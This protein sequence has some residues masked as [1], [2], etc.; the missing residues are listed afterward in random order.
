MSKDFSEYLKG[1]KKE[2]T[3]SNIDLK[4]LE[5]VFDQKK[6]EVKWWQIVI[7]NS[8]TTTALGILTQPLQVIHTT[9]QLSIKRMDFQ[10]N[11]LRDIM[12]AKITLGQQKKL[13]QILKL[14]IVKYQGPSYQ[15]YNAVFKGLGEQGVLGFYKGLGTGILY[16]I[17]N[18]QLRYFLIQK[19]FN[20][21][22]LIQNLYASLIGMAVDVLTNPFMLIQSKMI[23]QNRLPNF[24]TYRSIYD[25]L[26]KERNLYKGALG[27]IY[28]HIF[29]SLSQM[30]SIY[31]ND[32]RLCLSYLLMI[33][34]V[35]S[36]PF[37]T[38][39]RRLH[40]QGSQPFMLQT[41]YKGFWDGAKQI[42]QQEGILT[43][44][45]G[46]AAF[47]IAN[48]FMAFVLYSTQLLGESQE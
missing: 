29:I 44:Y 32:S 15:N 7:G 25:L 2:E 24:R 40:C 26:K 17:T 33:Q 13:E 35:V 3:T 36:Y 23:H 11:N 12:E 43:F 47:G 42:Y 31:I 21:K 48:S 16:Q 8:F 19:Y 41:N 5:S 14:K 20:E 28:K 27:H 4:E 38:V 6:Y 1:M 10:V 30:P 45:R 39:I 46:F 22:K 9:F 37:L 34:Q 18:S